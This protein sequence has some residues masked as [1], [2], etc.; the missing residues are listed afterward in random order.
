MALTPS[1]R[2]C[3]LIA[4]TIYFELILLPHIYAVKGYLSPLFSCLKDRLN[5]KKIS[6]RIFKLRLTEFWTIA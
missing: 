5:L 2:F 3:Y 1:I 4:D 6:I